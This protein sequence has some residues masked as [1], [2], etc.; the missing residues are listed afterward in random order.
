M[1][2]VYLK[3]YYVLIC[4]IFEHTSVAMAETKPEDFF[5]QKR[6]ASE[7]KAEILPKY[8]RAWHTRMAN[9][10]GTTTTNQV[11]FIDVH[12][13]TGY[14]APD[15]PAA[16]IK[17]LNQVH[18][19]NATGEE[20][21]LELKLYF[22]DAPG[23]TDKLIKNVETLPYYPELIHQVV[24]LKEAAEQELLTDVLNQPNPALLFIDL[25]GNAFARQLA[26]Q[27]MHRQGETDMLML[28]NLSKVKAALLTE[29]VGG[30]WHLI[31]GERLAQ[32]KQ[33][34]Q[35]EKSARKRDEFIITQ[36]EAACQA[37][38]FYTYTFKIA[39]PDKGQ[40]G[41]YLML[42]SKAKAGYLTIKELLQPYSDYQ[43][44]SVPLQ[45]ANLKQ[46]QPL[47]PGFFKYLNTYCLENL[48]EYLGANRSRFHYK[49]IVE[50][51]EEHGIGTPYSKQNY[52]AAFEK[53]REQGIINVVDTSNRKVKFITESAVIFYKL[54]GYSKVRS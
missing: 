30:P 9:L 22:T 2:Q 37:N 33:S 42:L 45:G 36:L 23:V 7:I 38:Y 44:D 11:Y 6:T 49:T 15:V 41:Y 48:V 53:L 18:D 10:P 3:P 39:Q 46:Q 14:E 4:I 51:Y 12:A 40:T 31:L 19:L 20:I 35:H 28:F 13:G 8:F 47:L 54:H 29:E 1:R 50:I 21:N 24:F 5:K 34:Y 52:L 26:G 17:I 16:P 32:I 25:F 43:E 27:V